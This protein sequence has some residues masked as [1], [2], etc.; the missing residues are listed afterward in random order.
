M[1]YFLWQTH[2]ANT[3]GSGVRGRL[4]SH[5]AYNR[6]DSAQLYQSQVQYDQRE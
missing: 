2:A 4:Q 6:Q 1:G 5:A 3:N